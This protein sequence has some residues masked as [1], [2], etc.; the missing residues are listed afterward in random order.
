M[1][2]TTV[3]PAYA[4]SGQTQAG[5]T[6]SSVRESRSFGRRQEAATITITRNGRAS[7]FRISPILFSIGFSIIAMFMVGYVG[8]TAYLVFRDDLIGAT[9]VRNARLLHEYEDRIAA[10]RAN[11]DQVT[12][13]QLLDQQAIEAKIAELIQR[14]DALA[15]RDSRIGKLIDAAEKRGLVQEAEGKAIEKSPDPVK[16]GSISPA[17]D[18]LLA[19]S[20]GFSLRGSRIS[21]ALSP[22]EQGSGAFVVSALKGTNLDNSGQAEA[23]FTN[24]SERIH[25]IDQSQK[26]AIS[27]LMQ[28]AGRKVERM[29]SVVARLNIAL[30]A[31]MQKNT[32]GPFIPVDPDASFESHVDALDQSIKAYDL[33]RN[34]IATIPLGNPARGHE[35]SSAF[36]RRS[37]PFLGTVAMHSGM[38]FRAP[39]GA[40]VRVTANGM[41]VDA[42][43]NGGYGNMVEV[44]HGNGFK[45]RYAHLSAISVKTGD[46]VRLGD[47][48]GKVGSTGRSTGPHLHYEVRRSGEAV[49]PARFLLA[50]R[51][52][53]AKL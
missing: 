43:R 19:D 7:H 24:V 27:D 8:A 6:A 16:T 33:V 26:A 21:D 3:S 11:L 32:G 44:D 40:S 14:Q 53:N 39:M 48:V 46:K 4:A 42:G 23:L 34:R 29:A 5:Q 10:L 28:A 2:Q 25:N 49:D 35:I 50:G 30:P 36:G 47:E 51:D 52:I 37:D 9:H 12:S 13:R 17:S 18:T 31:E 41:V 15:G 1:G 38:D 22:L 20:G 45:T